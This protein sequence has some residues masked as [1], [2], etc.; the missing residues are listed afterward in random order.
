MTIK[1]AYYY[2]FYKFYKFGEAS[3]SIFPSDFTA[4]FAISILEVLFLASFKFYS[5]EFLGRHGDL[6][7]VSFQVIVPLSTIFLLNYF[8]FINNTVW[9]KYIHEFDHLPSSKNNL[10][11]WIVIAITVFVIINFSLSTYLMR[12]ISIT[13]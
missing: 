3:P 5:T 11:T 12:Q 7:F 9:K 6:R 13:Q 2:F 4:A 10:G 8:A 1:K